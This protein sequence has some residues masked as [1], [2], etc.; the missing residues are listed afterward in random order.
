M[1]FLFLNYC[2]EQFLQEGDAEQEG[3]RW[4]R[5]TEEEG[6]QEEGM[7]LRPHKAFM[8]PIPKKTLSQ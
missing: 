2:I 3:E 6:E 1:L 5:R 4:E 7:K 8:S